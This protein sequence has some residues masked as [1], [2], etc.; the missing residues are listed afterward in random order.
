M[1]AI[2]IILTLAFVAATV[3][4]VARIWKLYKES[5]SKSRYHDPNDVF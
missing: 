5:R 2:Q 3:G 1:T 4:W